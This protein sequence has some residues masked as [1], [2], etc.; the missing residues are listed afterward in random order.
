MYKMINGQVHYA[1]RLVLAMAIGSLLGIARALST[2]RG[3]MCTHA[4]IS[5]GACLHHLLQPE[6]TVM[7]A[8]V[9]AAATMIKA[10]ETVRGINTAIG[11][12]V[13][14]G[15]GAACAHEEFAVALTAAAVAMLAQAMNRVVVGCKKKNVRSAGLEPATCEHTGS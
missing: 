9:L 2:Q 12:W 7:A 14:A 5:T 8:A 10:P 13:A 3:G 1:V 4:L 15:T 11:V 6:S